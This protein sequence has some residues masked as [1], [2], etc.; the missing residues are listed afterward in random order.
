LIYNPIK[1]ELII[2]QNGIVYDFLPVEW[3]SFKYEFDNDADKIIFL[4]NS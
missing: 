1:V 4:K 3:E 2:D